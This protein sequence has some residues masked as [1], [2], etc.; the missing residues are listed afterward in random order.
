MK[1]S[2]IALMLPLAASAAADQEL[3]QEQDKQLDE[4]LIEGRKPE[5][6]PQK[7]IDWM[8]RLV[9]EYT[10]EG[11]VDLKAKGRP[12]DFRPVRGS[13]NCFGFGPAP[14]VQCEI[15][16]HWTPVRAEDRGKVLGGISNLEPAM[17][18]FGFEPDR[19]G[20]RYMLVDSEGIAEGAMGYVVNDTLVSRAPCVNVPG[21]CERVARI[22]AHNDLKMIDMQVDLVIDYESAVRFHFVWRRVPGSKAVVVAGPKVFAEP[23]SQ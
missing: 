9:G 5:R 16:V 21:Q 1:G 17:M 11:E 8:A 19:F 15:N 23:E 7:V 10:F 13:G 6:N 14:A 20:I 12:Q 4:I 18:L 3:E 22:T 2:L